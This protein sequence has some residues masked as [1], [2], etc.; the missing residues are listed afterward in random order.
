MNARS[1]TPLALAIAMAAV[2]PSGFAK[3]GPGGPG[4]AQGAAALFL[5][6]PAEAADT[7]GNGKISREERQAAR[8]SEFKAIDINQTDG[9][10]SL[11][12]LQAW[13]AGKIAA[14]FTALDADTSGGLSAAE[15]AGSAKG[16]QAITANNLFKLADTDA[17]NA[18]SAEEFT[19]LA[20][21]AVNPIFPFAAM[22]ADGD[23]QVSA[24]EF[25]A[26]PPRPDRQRQA[27]QPGQF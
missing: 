10:A 23:G 27:R 3:G 6:P 5:G 13:T 7:D 26:R 9:Y 17:N 16:R 18:L 21:L 12:E 1:I 25:T 8:A 4:G 22:D 15:F 20:Q 11:A 2:S 24:A 19:A 14:R